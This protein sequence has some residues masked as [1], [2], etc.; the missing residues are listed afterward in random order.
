VPPWHAERQRQHGARLIAA[1]R[2]ADAIAA[3]TRVTRLDPRNARRH[4]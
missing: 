1:G 2:L 3:F 4:I